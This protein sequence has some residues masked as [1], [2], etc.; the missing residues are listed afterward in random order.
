M[1]EELW[2]KAF[3][4]I[5]FDI[6][7]IIGVG[8]YGKVAKVRQ[9][10]TGK[11]M[12]IKHVDKAAMSRMDLEEQLLNEIKI[13]KHLKHPNILNLIACFEDYKNV[14]LLMELST[15][16]DLYSRLPPTGMT[17]YEAAKVVAYKSDCC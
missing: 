8:A 5:E 10:S 3:K 13:M 11:L 15:E 14:H 9:K 7:E 6:V 12:A 2:D 1:P 4:M 17:E 16:G